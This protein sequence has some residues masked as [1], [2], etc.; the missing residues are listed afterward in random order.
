MRFDADIEKLSLRLDHEPCVQVSASE[1]LAV[2]LAKMKTSFFLRGEAGSAVTRSAASGRVEFIAAG[3][4]LE[5]TIIAVRA[6]ESPR[7]QESSLWQLLGSR[8]RIYLTSALF[9]IDP[10][11]LRP[12][13][14][15]KKNDAV[16][17]WPLCD[18]SI[19]KYGRDFV[20]VR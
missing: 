2:G 10:R 14:V 12:L 4:P 9:G 6:R 16:P 3:A 8:M 13:T 19:S 5:L 1:P 15:R 7:K 18:V 20:A 11:R 17:A